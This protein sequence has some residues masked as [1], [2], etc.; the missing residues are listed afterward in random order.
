MPL[1]ITN[2]NNR[3]LVYNISDMLLHHA[4]LHKN[5]TTTIPSKSN[6]ICATNSPPPGHAAGPVCSCIAPALRL[7]CWQS[8]NR[9]A[10]ADDLLSKKV[11]HLH[12]K[13]TPFSTAVNRCFPTSSRRACLAEMLLTCC[14]SMDC[15]EMRVLFD[16][17]V[18]RLSSNRL[19]T[20][21]RLVQRALPSAAPPA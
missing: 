15:S 3:Q 2:L 9:R 6:R 4:R 17:K 13:T 5:A 14:P 20:S 21:A 18:S 12:A 7:M 10:Y 8:K 11:L 19:S 16:C 1:T